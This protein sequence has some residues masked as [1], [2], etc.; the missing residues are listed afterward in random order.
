MDERRLRAWA[1]ARTLVA[2]RWTSADF[3]AWRIR[4]EQI[5]FVAASLGGLAAVA[6]GADEVGG[7]DRISDSSRR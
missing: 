2:S 5:S 1:L 7:V 6:R 3:E 4:S